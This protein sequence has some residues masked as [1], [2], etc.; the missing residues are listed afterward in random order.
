M[1]TVASHK[2]LFTHYQKDGVDNHSY[3]REFMAHVETVETYGVTGTIEVG[4]LAAKI[5]NWLGQGRLL[6]PPIQWTLK[7]LPPF[8][9]SAKSTLPPSC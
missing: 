8:L 2:R 4:L 7:R 6:M 1:A 3:H 9:L 5:Q